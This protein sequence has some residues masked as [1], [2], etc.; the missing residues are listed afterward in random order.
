MMEQRRQARRFFDLAWLGTGAEGA[1]DP[2]MAYNR[3]LWGENWTYGYVNIIICHPMYCAGASQCE[4]S[5]ATESL[6]RQLSR[7]KK[8]S[9]LKTG[10]QTNK[11]SRV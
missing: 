10:R 3:E 2:M 7:P 4:P 5:E 6:D 8:L 9:V 1:V 11:G